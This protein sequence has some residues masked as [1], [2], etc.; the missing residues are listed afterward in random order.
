MRVL[1]RF[2]DAT[3]I[4]AKPI[5]GRTHQIRVHTQHIGHPIL[6]DNK[7]Q[8]DQSESRS[9]TIG[10]KRLFL[11]AAAIQFEVNNQRYDLSCPLDPELESVL[12]KLRTER[13]G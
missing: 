9:S 5:S 4:E 1:E 8:N 12:S 2:P 6:G 3:L 7:Y 13:K 10:L 11:H